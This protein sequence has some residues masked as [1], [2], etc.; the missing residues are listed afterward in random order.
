MTSSVYLVFLCSNIKRTFIKYKSWSQTIT[1]FCTI[2]VFGIP[3]L[4][5]CLWQGA[6]SDLGL[7]RLI[8]G[9]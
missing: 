5:P 1:D 7:F 4:W 3:G 6:L 9:V 8:F 2:E